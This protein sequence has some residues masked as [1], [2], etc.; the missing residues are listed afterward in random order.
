MG[1]IT[2]VIGIQFIID[3]VTAVRTEITKTSRAG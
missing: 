3:G 1:L 2:A